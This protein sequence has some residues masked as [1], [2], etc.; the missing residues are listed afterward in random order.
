MGCLWLSYFI[1]LEQFFILTLIR[2]DVPD[3]VLFKK[4][5]IYL[6]LERGKGERQRNI[7]V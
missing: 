5:I 6:F 3:I 1:S 4:D 7:S 2:M